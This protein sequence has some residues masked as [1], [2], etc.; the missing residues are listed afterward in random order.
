[1]FT[2]EQKDAD[3]SEAKVHCSAA[4]TPLPRTL[5]RDPPTWFTPIDRSTGEGLEALHDA[6]QVLSLLREFRSITE[7]PLT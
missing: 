7:N 4:K 1:M 6:L 2:S 5:S 3:S